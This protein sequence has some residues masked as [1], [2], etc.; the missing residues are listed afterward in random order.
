MTRAPNF[1]ALGAALAAFGIMLGAFGA[2]A[3]RSVASTE[4]LGWW[5]TA[6]RYF[7]TGALGMLAFGLWRRQ[8]PGNPLA[9]WAL[10]AGMTL[11]S[12]SLCAMALGAPRWFGAITPFGGLGLIAGFLL[13]ALEARR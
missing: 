12:G 1:V 13:F 5:E 4:Q 3:L 6:A 8:A 11:F 9:G 7:L 10:L 2:H